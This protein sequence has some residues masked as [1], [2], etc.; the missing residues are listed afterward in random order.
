MALETKEEVIE[1]LRQPLID[2]GIAIVDAALSRYKSSVTFKLFIYSDKGTTLE[3]CSRVSHLVG[4][5]IE[6]T[7]YFKNGYTLEVS[8]PGLDRPLTTMIDFKYR[9]GEKVRITFVEPK[10]KKEEAE[11]TGV[12]NS[13]VILVGK[14]GVYRLN[15]DEIKEAKIIF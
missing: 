8:S 3:E 10:R 9:I 11:I 4:E 2:E 6:G 1:L 15:L 12:E 13:T 14:D 7:D 5:I